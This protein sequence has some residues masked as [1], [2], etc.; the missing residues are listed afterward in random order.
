MLQEN[1][2]RKRWNHTSLEYISQ[3]ELGVGKIEHEEKFQ[4]FWRNNLDKFIEYNI[5]DVYP[6]KVRE[7]KGIVKYFD[8]IR[9]F[10]FCSQG[11]MY[12]TVRCWIVSSYSRLRSMVLSY[13][14]LVSRRIMKDYRRYCH[15]TNGRSPSERCC[16]WVMCVCIL[17]RFL[18]CNNM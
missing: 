13:P 14:L 7:S 4:D 15:Y 8:T 18:T 3:K 1:C 11:M 9:R 6:Y 17:L 2:L 10:T 5:K 16:G 12:S